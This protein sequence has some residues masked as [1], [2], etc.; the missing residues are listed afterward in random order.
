MKKEIKRYLKTEKEFKKAKQKLALAII[1]G[2]FTGASFRD[3][4][5]MFPFKVHPQTIK[6]IIT[7]GW[8]P[9]FSLGGKSCRHKSS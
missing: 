9:R 5:K 7:Q 8:T 2:H 6:N 4:A 1:A 3:I